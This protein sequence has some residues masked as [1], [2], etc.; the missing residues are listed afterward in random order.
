ML[1]CVQ[2]FLLLTIKHI[3]SQIKE[4]LSSNCGKFTLNFEHGQTKDKLLFSL[5]DFNMNQAVK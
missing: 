2:I 5:I 1:A 3:H 4:N